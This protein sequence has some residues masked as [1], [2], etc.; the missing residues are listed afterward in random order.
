[1]P[2]ALGQTLFLNDRS[3]IVVVAG[4]ANPDEEVRQPIAD[5]AFTGL[6]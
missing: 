2:G 4:Q 1:M 5:S 6:G 3:C